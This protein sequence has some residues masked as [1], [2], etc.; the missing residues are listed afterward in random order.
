MRSTSTGLKLVLV[1]T[2]FTALNACSR[3]TPYHFDT[4]ILDGT[5]FDGSGSA[6]YVGDLGIIDSRIVAIGQL[7]SSTANY[8][9]NAQGKAVSPGF[10]NMI[11]WGVTSLINDGRGLSDISQGITLEVFGEGNSMGPLSPSMQADFPKYWAGIEPQW[12]TLGE[13]L[14]F[15]E[16]KGVAPNIASFI[17][18]T[19]PRINVLGYNDVDP[20]PDELNR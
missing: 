11:G 12:T 7:D 6:S 17:G 20:T 15:L 16:A 13:Y 4:L 3:G 2:L 14:E 10:I 18:A 19:T 1:A 5:I 9:I 8:V